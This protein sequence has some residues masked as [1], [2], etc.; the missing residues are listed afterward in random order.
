VDCCG[1]GD[2]VHMKYDDRGR[3]EDVTAGAS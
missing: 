2:A 1:D 3:R